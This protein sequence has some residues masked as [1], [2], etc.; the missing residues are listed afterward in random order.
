[1]IINATETPYDDV[2]DLVIR[3][4]LGETLLAVDEAVQKTRNLEGG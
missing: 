1:M 2:A 4:P 3:A